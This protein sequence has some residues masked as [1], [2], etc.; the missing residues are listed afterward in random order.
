MAAGTG[1][2]S[3]LERFRRDLGQHLGRCAEALHGSLAQHQEFVRG[4]EQA[5]AMGDDDARGSLFLERA[6]RRMQGLLAL[7]VE[8]GIGFVQHDEAR[9]AI[10]G[11]RQRDP[12]PLPGREQGAR[13]ADGCVV[14]VGQPEDQLV[15]I[16][17]LRGGDD[18]GGVG[19]AHARDVLADRPREK[20]DILRQIADVLAQV[21]ARPSGD[22]GAIEAYRAPSRR[23][24][25]H[26]QPSEGRLAR[27]A[28][29]DH[30]E[31]F[32]R[33]ES[34]RNPLDHH[35]L[36]IAETEH[37]TLQRDCASRRRQRRD[38]LV[39]ATRPQ[40]AIQA[41][42]SASRVDQG[43]PTCYHAFDRGEGTPEQNGR[44]DHDTRARVETDDEVCPHAQHRDLNRLAHEL[45]CRGYPRRGPAGSELRGEDFVMTSF[46]TRQDTRGHA[47][48]GDRLGI[49]QA[50]IDEL[51]RLA[52]LCLHRLQ[53]L[54]RES[55]VGDRQDQEDQ[56]ADE[57]HQSEQR[58]KQADDDDVDGNPGDVEEREDRGAGE[59]RAQNRNVPQRMLGIVR[60]RPTAAGQH[61]A[62]HDGAERLVESDCPARQ[63][64][65]AD[66]VQRCHHHE[67][68]HREHGQH[69][70]RFVAAARHDA[71]EH[72]QHV[73]CR[74]DQQQV[75]HQ[76]E[77]TGK[78]EERAEAGDELEHF[79]RRT[80][81]LP[82]ASP[83][84]A[85]CGPFSPGSMI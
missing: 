60:R 1:P 54:A 85:M 25:A 57:R 30:R 58:M 72:L 10:Q 49:A 75:D 21:L 83:F 66:E 35:V 84:P 70:Q 67:G 53:W 27:R 4:F 20:L 28:G 59:E 6:E 15:R 23:P 63:E 68:H 64:L 3:R 5:G 82:W 44:G 40:Q 45:G 51:R 50:Q 9:V 48:R 13:V 65:G 31:R 62:Q 56:R 19:A 22:V 14:A 26:H 24:D 38:R 8:I 34:E 47:H 41:T 81:P 73:D 55:F 12:L 76:A 32:A 16:G 2:A 17:T 77:Q 39:V 33:R 74:H 29:A 78:K 79:C 69:D 7:G 36:P 18:S 61:L 43:F 71:I 37:H 42:V 11:T 46:P 52:R 80:P